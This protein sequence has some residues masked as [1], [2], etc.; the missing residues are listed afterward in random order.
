VNRAYYV[1]P[2]SAFLVA[3]AAFAI[4]RAAPG[5]SLLNVILGL[6]AFS[7]TILLTLVLANR[8]KRAW[9]P[10]VMPSG[11]RYTAWRRSRQRQHRLGSSGACVL[12][13]LRRLPTLLQQWRQKCQ[14]TH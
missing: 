4:A 7:A 2:F 3:L 5:S 11:L 12:R 9:L 13:P 10:L 8:P 6:G 14:T 1:S